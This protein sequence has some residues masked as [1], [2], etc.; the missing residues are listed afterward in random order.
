MSLEAFYAVSALIVLLLTGIPIALALTLAGAFGLWLLDFP[1]L[2]VIQRFAAGSE[3]FVLLAIPFFIL[4]GAVMEAGGISRRL[5]GFC[6]AC[7]GYLPGGLANANIGASMVFGGISGS[8][9]ADTSAVGS[10]MIPAMEREGYSRRYSAAVTAA[11]SPV[12]MII[13]PSIPMIVWS[14][15]SGQSLNELFMAG[16]V[17]GILITLALALV[18]TWICQRRGF[19]RGFRPFRAGFFLSSLKDGLLALGAPVI[20]IGG[21]LIGAFT[22]T[23]ASVVALA[24]ALILSFG[25]YRELSPRKLAAVFV[26]AGKTSASIMFIICGATVFSFFLTVS[27]MPAQIGSLILSVSETPL[28]F[29][30]AAGLLMFVLGMFLD[31]TTTIL[32]AGPIIIP[33]F[34]QVGVDP[35]V[36]TMVIMVILAIGLITPPVGLCLFVVSS[37]TPVK[38][39]DVA[40]E[41]VPFILAMTA[42]AALIWIFPPLVTWVVP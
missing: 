42:V 37:I 29:I 3:S 28:G 15:I 12:G 23:E 30:I 13:P 11:A 9:V 32:M 2:V 7:L 24:Y 22:P 4:A 26:Q 18:S 38:V 36:A 10:V 1:M 39:W 17:P 40:R 27:G 19:Q 41:C 8:A 21:I 5:I 33:L 25:V 35:L 20:I 34:S 31:T 16:I 14:Y 6:D